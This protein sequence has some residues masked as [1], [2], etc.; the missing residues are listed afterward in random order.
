MFSATAGEHSAA[1]YV[2]VAQMA[3]YSLKST[4]GVH[5]ATHQSFTG[6][7]PATAAVFWVRV[8]CNTSSACPMGAFKQVRSL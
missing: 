7:L 6:G 8:P 5:P 2:S 3:Y 1:E 4:P